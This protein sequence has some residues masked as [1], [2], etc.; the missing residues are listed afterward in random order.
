VKF[1][2]FKVKQDVVV[3]F[4]ADEQLMA[5]LNKSEELKKVVHDIARK[6]EYLA[7]T[8]Y[9]DEECYIYPDNFVVSVTRDFDGVL[10]V[11][12]EPSIVCDN[13]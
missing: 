12:I 10:R 6:I 3:V 11:R 1:I 9:N 13:T 2:E 5:A 8:V 7:D 4:S